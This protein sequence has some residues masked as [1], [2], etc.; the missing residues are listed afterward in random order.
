MIHRSGWFSIRSWQT[1]KNF[2]VRSDG[3]SSP[4]PTTKS[5]S[6][7]RRCVVL[8][9]QFLFNWDR[10]PRELVSQ[11]QRILSWSSGGKLGSAAKVASSNASVDVWLD[12]MRAGNKEI[13]ISGRLKGCEK[14]VGGTCVYGTSEDAKDLPY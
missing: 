8:L 1:T 7:Q 5:I 3:S 14:E 6:L 12:M 10:T 13:V 11:H 9:F 4:H 2:R